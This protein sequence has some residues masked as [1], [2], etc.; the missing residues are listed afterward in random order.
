MSLRDSEWYLNYINAFRDR[1]KVRG[2]NSFERIDFVKNR[3][4]KVINDSESDSSQY[5]KAYSDTH[6]KALC[7]LEGSSDE[8]TITY[9]LETI[10]GI[11]MADRSGPECSYIIAGEL[12]AYGYIIAELEAVL[13]G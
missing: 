10:V 11:V 8:R 13:N 5:R 6:K 12:D 4:R 7:I 9:K 3:W 1:T 2:K